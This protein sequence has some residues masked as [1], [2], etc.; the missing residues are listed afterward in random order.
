MNNL[1]SSSKPW[2]V[3]DHTSDKRSQAEATFAKLA[4]ALAYVTFCRKTPSVITFKHRGHEVH[5]YAGRGA[6]EEN[7][8]ND[9][10]AL[11]VRSLQRRIR[12]A[13]AD[14]A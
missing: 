11:A 14:V 13:D 1:D 10:A 12:P 6:T 5:A 2:V 9:V 3:Y 8:R 4:D 7:L